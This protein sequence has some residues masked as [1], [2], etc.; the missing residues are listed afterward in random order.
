MLIAQG[1][2]AAEDPETAARAT[3][4]L[5]ETRL[6]RLEFLLNGTTN[7]HGVPDTLPAVS[8]ESDMVW[9]KLNA[10]DSRLASLKKN[11]GLAESVV[12]DIERLC[13]SC[14]SVSDK[15]F[16]L[17]ILQQP[18]IRICF[19]RPLP[20]IPPSQTVKTSLRSPQSFFP[21][22]VFSRRLMPVSP[23]SKHFI[24]LRPKAVQNSWLSDR[25][26]TSVNRRSVS[27]TW[28]YESFANGVQDVW[29]GGSRSELLVR[30][31]CGKIG[32]AEF[33]M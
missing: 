21:T 16:N 22:Q 18:F 10:L 32:R 23:P 29:N 11:G 20:K 17:T 25:E 28:K 12:T 1:S 8:K 4:A 3:L 19:P 31:I 9:T 5:L 27:W 26:L 14:L 6:H 33:L 7:E 30:V 15:A 2:M 13:R 24:F